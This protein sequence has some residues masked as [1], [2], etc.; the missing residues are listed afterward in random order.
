M[1][2]LF[3]LSVM[4]PAQN[5]RSL[6]RSVVVNRCAFDGKFLFIVQFQL[7]GVLLEYQNKENYFINQI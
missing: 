1:V 5:F 6:I 3:F 7:G 2:E 4:N